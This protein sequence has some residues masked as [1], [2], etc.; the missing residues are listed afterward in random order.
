MKPLNH[1]TPPSPQT[2]PKPALES[3][4]PSD[5]DGEVAETPQSGAVQQADPSSGERAKEREDIKSIVTKAV[6]R[7]A[8]Q[9]ASERWNRL[10]SWVL[11]VGGTG[12]VALWTGLVLALPDAQ[13]PAPGRVVITGM[14]IGAACAVAGAILLLVASFKPAVGV[15]AAVEALEAQKRL[16]RMNA[17]TEVALLEVETKRREFRD[18]QS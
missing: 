17:E 2:P 9:A 10:A 6:E 12:L 7:A 1:P 14:I 13:M 11:F 5:P 15:R 4:P 18:R 3:R 8:K 16:E